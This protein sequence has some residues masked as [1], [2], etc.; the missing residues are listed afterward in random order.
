MIAA[1]DITRFQPEYRSR[2]QEVLPPSAF[3]KATGYLFENDQ[4]RSIGG[5]LLKR[6]LLE[7]VTGISSSEQAFRLSGYGKPE[8]ATTGAVHF[9]LS[10]SGDWVVLAIDENPVGIDVE[11]IKADIPDVEEVVFSAGEIEFLRNLP[12]QDRR[13][14]FFHL[15]TRKECYIKALG[16]G[17]SAPLK[18]I[19]ILPGDQR[20]YRIIADGLDTDWSVRQIEVGPGYSAAICTKEVQEDSV[21]YHNWNDLYTSLLKTRNI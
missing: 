21:Q 8:L 18:S 11:Q 16:L 20:E 13:L 14:Q 7:K 3:K 2:L 15:W 5:E 6:V 4:L 9:N 17:F 10:H 12:D 1:L 19:S